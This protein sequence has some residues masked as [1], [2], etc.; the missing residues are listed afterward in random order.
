MTFSRL[1]AV[2]T[3][4]HESQSSAASASSNLRESMSAIELRLTP[5]ELDYLEH[6][7]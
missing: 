3:F 6:V 1:S 2:A 4:C 5:E 7:S